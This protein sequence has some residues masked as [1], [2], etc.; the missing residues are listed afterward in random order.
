MTSTE[1]LQKDST[2][3]TDQRVLVFDF[4]SQY[5]QLIARRVREQNVYCEIVRHDISAE[6]VREHN[7]SGLILSGGPAS[8]Y[9]D[10]APK[11][12]PEIFNLGLPV[13]AIC[14]GMHVACE[15]L[16]GE[17]KSTPTREYGRAVC[18]VTES[19]GLFDNLPEKSDVWMSH[20]DQVSSV[21]SN[22][23][24]LAKTT[25]C[26]Y[27]AVK[28]RELDVYGLQFHPEVAHTELGSKILANFLRSVCKCQGTWKLGDFAQEAI[29]NIR[30][31]VGKGSGTA[32]GQDGQFALRVQCH[33]MGRCPGMI[34]PFKAHN[35][36]I[37][38]L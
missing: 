9:A 25:T 34:D 14:Y 16:G 7:P 23:L 35:R 21:S 19:G 13:L 17:V 36:E 11:C 26:P 30:Q 37:V 12:D 22:F 1:T 33:E 8:V 29:E 10:N 31:Q 20:G 24:P 15:A 3:L 28:H 18:E 2:R 6:R 5:A 32:N 38:F 27:A 4:G